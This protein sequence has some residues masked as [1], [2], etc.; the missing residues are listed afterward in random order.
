MLIYKAYDI[1]IF[2]EPIMSLLDPPAIFNIKNNEKNIDFRK[3][4]KM[5]Y[6]KKKIKFLKETI[7]NSLCKNIAIA[8]MCIIPYLKEDNHRF[9]VLE[10][11]FALDKKY[12]P[13]L[14]NIESEVK[15]NKKHWSEQVFNEELIDSLRGKL[16]SNLI[17]NVKCRSH[18][19]FN[20]RDQRCP[21]AN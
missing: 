20:R 10:F 18:R 1:R 14:I 15:L 9:Q 16:R 2:N 13:W 3:F 12:E 6:N 7:W 11:Q 4:C 8:L 5:I 19:L 17:L 21:R